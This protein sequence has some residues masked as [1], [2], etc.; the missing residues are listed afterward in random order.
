VRP[1]WSNRAKSQVTSLRDYAT[2]VAPDGTVVEIDRDRKR[3]VWWTLAGLNANF[4]LAASWPGAAR[5]DNFSVTP[6]GHVPVD[7][8]QMWIRRQGSVDPSHLAHLPRPKFHE[9]L[10]SEVLIMMLRARTQDLTS[11]AAARNGPVLY[12][13][14]AR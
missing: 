11:V 9:S 7:P 3:L 14:V 13:Y 1:W 10:P 12:R 8:V 2:A 5:F 6:E 4:E